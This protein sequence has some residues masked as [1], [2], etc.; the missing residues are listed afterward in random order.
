MRE[1]W[2]YKKTEVIMNKVVRFAVL[3]TGMLLVFVALGHAQLCDEQVPNSLR[4]PEWLGKP[5]DLPE[6]IPLGMGLCIVSKPARSGLADLQLRIFPRLPYDSIRAKLSLF[7]GLDVRGPADWLVEKGSGDT[8]VYPVEV[9]IPD[10]DTAGI[11]AWI[12]ADG[13]RVNSGCMYFVNTGDTLSGDTF[14][15]WYK[16]EKEEHVPAPDTINIRHESIILPEGIL[17]RTAQGR[18]ELREPLVH[19]AHVRNVGWATCMGGL[20][21]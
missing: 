9:M 20:W 1:A 19:H 7:G 13:I 3:V 5:S 14:D 15:L 10:Q 4:W 6:E 2:G 21:K 12:F 11:E 8:V 17:A 16:R 18:K